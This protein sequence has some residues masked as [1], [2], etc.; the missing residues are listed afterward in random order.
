MTA[1]ADIRFVYDPILGHADIVLEESKRDVQ[2]DK[3]LETAVLISLFTN[4]RVDEEDLL[5]DGVNEKS[6]WWG[7]AVDDSPFVGSRL[8]LLRRAKNTTR[9]RT[10][11][12]EYAKEAL[13]WMISQGVAEKV[14]VSAVDEDRRTVLLIVNVVRPEVSGVGQFTYRYYYN[15][16]SQIIRRG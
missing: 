13:S 9:V 12:E 16:E 6:G 8:W 4:K 14:E 3:G 7:F 2:S 10:L 15:W 5:P 11:S 1:E